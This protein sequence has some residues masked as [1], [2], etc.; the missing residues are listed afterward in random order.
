MT[1]P[2]L[3]FSI[4]ACCCVV[5]HCCCCNHCCITLRRNLVAA[6][7]AAIDSSFTEGT[8]SSNS[9]ACFVSRIRDQ[10]IAYLAVQALT[11]CCLQK[12][13]VLVYS[14]VTTTTVAAID[15]AF[16][17]DRC[18]KDWIENCSTTCQKLRTCLSC[19]LDCC[20][21]HSRPSSCL[22]CFTAQLSNTTITTSTF[23]GS[24]SFVASS[25]SIIAE[26]AGCST[27]TTTDCRTSSCSPATSMVEAK[28]SGS[29]SGWA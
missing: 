3:M 1:K 12:L 21:Y 6:R 15:F 11:S 28:T 7:L 5:N 14:I 20:Y 22:H 17:I 18:Q 23:I 29:C 2:R 16:W 8:G 13:W 19:C 10:R 25:S 4:A 9:S 24:S 26:R 27:S